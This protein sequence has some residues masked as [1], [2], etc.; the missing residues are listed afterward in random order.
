MIPSSMLGLAILAASAL[1]PAT[2]PIH[3]TGTITNDDYPASAARAGA[4][5][6][7]TIR[8]Q[9]GENGRVVGCEIL[10][11]SGNSSLDSTS[12][13][14]AVRRFRFVPAV[15]S[16]GQPTSGEVVRTVSWALPPPPTLPL[17]PPPLAARPDG[18]PSPVGPPPVAARSPVLR[19]GSI[20][21]QDYPASAIRA[22]AQGAVTMRVAV[23][24]DGQVDGCTILASSGN[25]AL[26]GTTC[27]LAISRFR[28][29]PAHDATGRPIR[30]E[31]AWTVR[32]SLP[33]P[34]EG[35]PPPEPGPQPPSQ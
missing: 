14:L 26:D 20:S 15:D 34:E 28:F 35:P 30:G 1:E 7:A 8:L 4:E 17:A 24:E 22:G 32:W 25:R 3:R 29:T 9:V 10:V 19:S 16:S 33:A 23:K 11:S 31:R 21:N 13:S 6:S 12:C 5:G 27:G 18:P 2:P